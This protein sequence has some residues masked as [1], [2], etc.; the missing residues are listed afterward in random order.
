MKA[1]LFLLLLFTATINSCKCTKEAS[2][3]TKLTA[4]NSVSVLQLRL[5]YQSYLKDRIDNGFDTVSTSTDL[6]FKI[7]K[8]QNQ[9]ELTYDKIVTLNCKDIQI[10]CNN[11][12]EAPTCNRL[13]VKP[14]GK[15]RVGSCDT[16]GNIQN[17]I[18]P[19][20]FDTKKASI[21]ITR[22]EDHFVSKITIDQNSPKVMDY[23]VGKIKHNIKPNKSYNITVTETF[24]NNEV[25]NYTIPNVT[26]KS[27]NHI[28]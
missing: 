19:I 25:L 4:K 3:E 21:K 18:F 26:F 23:Y 9:L 7:I 28:Q 24:K 10:F 6:D 16:Y 5:L 8:E 20:D 13:G 1:K 15:C 12:C 2:Q 17:L 27:A 11:D 14:T 22:P